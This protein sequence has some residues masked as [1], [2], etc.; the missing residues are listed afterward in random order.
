MATP[1]FP[2]VVTVQSFTAAI[3][4]TTDSSGNA[5]VPL[6]T[7]TAPTSVALPPNAKVGDVVV[8]QGNASGIT[9]VQ[10]PTSGFILA[11]GAIAVLVASA[12]LTWLLF[13][14]LPVMPAIGPGVGA[15]TVSLGGPNNVPAGIAAPGAPAGWEPRA[16]ADGTVGLSPFWK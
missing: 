3:V 16:L 14:G 13:N 6:P 2:P 9:T 11:P 5:V 1:N 8:V 4:V 12:S 10:G 7:I 15:G